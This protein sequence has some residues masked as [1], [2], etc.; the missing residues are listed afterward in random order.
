MLH[1]NVWL[2]WTFQS[3][4]NKKSL[5][6]FFIFGYYKYQYS[7]G[8]RAKCSLKV[9]LSFSLSLVLKLFHRCWVCPWVNQISPSGFGAGIRPRVDW[10]TRAVIHPLIKA[11]AA[12][13]HEEIADRSQLQTQL[14]GDGDLELFGWTLVL[15]EDGMES[16]P[17]N[18]REHQPGLLAH[19]SPLAPSVVLLLTFA[20]FGQFRD[21][22]QQLEDKCEQL[23]AKYV[24]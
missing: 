24:S 19:I 5:V 15:L 6:C 21:G 1:I 9:F 13:I 8:L 7:T 12:C 16:P 2:K 11:P 23:R 22:T 4:S 14:L 17:L 18:V 20:C 10:V 3:R